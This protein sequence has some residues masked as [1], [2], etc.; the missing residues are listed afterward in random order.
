MVQSYTED[1]QVVW[2]D[3]ADAEL[4]WS[5]DKFHGPRPVPPLAADIGARTTE[6]VFNGRSIYLNGYAYTTGWTLPGPTPEVLER[7][8]VNVWENDYA[9]LI[10]EACR[11]L[12]SADYDSMSAED[13]A[14][15][16][17]Q[18]VTDACDAFRHT[19]YVVMGFFLPTNLLAD[20]CEQELGPDGVQLAV[21]MLQ[22]FDNE[23]AEAGAGLGELAAEAARLPDVAAAIRERRYDDLASVKGGPEFL[24]RFHAYLDE[25][26]WRVD[27]WGLLH[28]ET[29]TENPRTPLM[30]I[31]RYLSDA[32]SSPAAAIK[33]SND[34]REEAAREIKSRLDDAQL[35]RF[36]EL[37][38]ACRAHVSISEG[39]AFWQLTIDGSLRVPILA[40]GRKLVAAGVIEEPNDIFFLSDEEVQEAARGPS[41][42]LR[43]AVKTRKA[44]LQRWEQ[45]SPRP[46]VGAPPPPSPMPPEIQRGIARF[47]GSD[48]GPSNEDNVIK[49]HGASRGVVKG[50]A[51]VLVELA[52]AERLQQGEILVCRST[53]PPWTPLFAIAAGIV[54]DSGGILSHSAICARE[55]G[56]PCVVGTQIGTKQIPDGAMITVDGGEGTVRIEG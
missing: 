10:R 47:Y 44:D 43:E 8:A 29:W 26:G 38:G 6:R 42:S 48:L 34:Q 27:N 9:P 2:R 40:L 24:E 22:G 31:G 53:A 23:S 45:M 7:G 3:P 16:L 15:S 25:Y 12:R 33:R 19:F 39:R 4:H 49:G 37:L 55:Y 18:L 50:R 11:R 36:D 54:T 52:Q 32:Q 46:F 5:W 13:L 41:G 28:V 51:R 30:L 20:F 1:F 35:A 56:I 21:T 14:G 17:D